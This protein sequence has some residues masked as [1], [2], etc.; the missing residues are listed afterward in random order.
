MAPPIIF[1]GPS[2]KI[3]RARSIFPLAEYRPPAKKGDLLRLATEDDG[4]QS[5]VGLIDGVFLQDYPPTPIEVYTFLRKRRTLLAGAAS[6]GALRAVELERFGMVG[7]GRIFKL[8]KSGRL[9]SDDEVAVTF[10]EPDYRLQSEAMIDIRYT[11]HWAARERVISP[12]TKRMLARIAKRIYFP[13]RSY[14]EMIERARA[15]GAVGQGELERFGEYV[16]T[17][18]RSL[19]EEDSV[20]LIEF[21][22]QRYLES[23]KT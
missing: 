15:A 20:R 8:Y 2:L 11:L 7:I 3:E 13:S 12:D 1:L 10:S 5:F 18:R 22:K 17:H 14:E 6:L 21:M 23:L 19:K 9:D 16:I 4:N